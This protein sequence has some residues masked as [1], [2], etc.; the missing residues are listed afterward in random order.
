MPRPK[1]IYLV[2]IDGGSDWAAIG[3]TIKAKDLW[4]SFLNCI[5]HISSLAINGIGK[6]DLMKSLVDQG[7]DVQT[8]SSANSKVGTILM[9]FCRKY[10]GRHECSCGY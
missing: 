6:L 9:N 10:M 5:A 7:I 3:S 4:I 8:W 2:A 1:A